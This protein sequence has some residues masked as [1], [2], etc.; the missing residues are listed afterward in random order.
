MCKSHAD[1]RRSAIF[2]RLPRYCDIS[3]MNLYAGKSGATS[4]KTE[5]PLSTSRYENTRTRL[6]SPERTT[7]PRHFIAKRTGLDGWGLGVVC[8]GRIDEAQPQC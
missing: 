5:S 3:R 8:G 2:C 1:I 7:F 4:D 6:Q